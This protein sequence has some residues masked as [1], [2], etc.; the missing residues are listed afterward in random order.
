[1]FFFL[2]TDKNSQFITKHNWL[3]LGLSGSRLLFL[4]IFVVCLPSSKCFIYLFFY[5]SALSFV[6]VLGSRCPVVVVLVGG[7]M[8]VGVVVVCV[9]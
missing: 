7:V 8:V 3:N 5:L 4:P 2:L 9:L 1:V 6:F